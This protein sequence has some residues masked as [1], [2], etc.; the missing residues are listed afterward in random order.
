MNTSRG[1][2]AS[3]LMRVKVSMVEQ[4]SFIYY[5]LSPLLFLLSFFWSVCS[6]NIYVCSPET[7][8]L[9]SK[10]LK[11]QENKFNSDRL[12]WLTLVN[13]ML[14]FKHIQMSQWIIPLWLFLSLCHLH[15]HI[16]NTVCCSISAARCTEPPVTGPCR[17][18]FTKWFYDPYDQTCTRF[19]YGGCSGNDNQFETEELCMTA[20]R[21]VTGERNWTEK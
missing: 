6:C 18:S 2:S 11:I 20:C 10:K 8:Y 5:F 9:P 3:K 17:A 1:F 19:N 7:V 12:T 21:G 13:D 4:I 15:R 16:N 14:F